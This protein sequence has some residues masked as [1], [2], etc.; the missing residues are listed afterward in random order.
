MNEMM[1]LTVG[2]FIL[3][4]ISY[5][6]SEYDFFSPSFIIC[7]MFTFGSM[8]ALYA[9]ATWG[10][11]EE[12][13]S[14][15]ATWIMLTGVMV[16]I[17]FEQITR[18]VLVGH[19]RKVVVLQ[20]KA[21]HVSTI[22]LVI[23]L[24]FSILEVVIYVY[25]VY[26]K[27]QA[28]G[29][30]GGFNFSAIA[31]FNHELTFRSDVEEGLNRGIR[32]L[33]QAAESIMFICTFV[34]CNNVILCKE[35]ILKNI[36]YLIPIIVWVPNMLI[37]S[38]RTMYLQ[39]IGA[40]VFYL[41]ILICRK[42]NW[43]RMKRNHKKIIKYAVI[44]FT[45]MVGLF[46]GAVANGLIG[47]QTNKTFMDY[48][49]V[50]IGAPIIHFHQFM[51]SPPPDVSVFGQETFTKVVPLFYRLGIIDSNYSAQMEIR[52]IIGTYSGNVYTFFRRPLHDF[53]LFGMYIIVALT[54]MG[55][56]WFYYK[57]I[58]GSNQ[59]KRND[60]NLILYSF[61]L[62]IIYIF[63]VDNALYI[64][65][66]FGIVYYIAITYFVFGLMFGSKYRFRIKKHS[67]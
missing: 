29:Y 33:H 17:L 6:L 9:T 62:Y 24:A 15:S 47:R 36:H 45:V 10:V 1:I 67:G 51:T 22:K 23:L 8:L 25:A 57:K 40:A 30:S 34:F 5:F 39:V 37:T 53:G 38:S 54:A 16:F 60:R 43:R 3:L 2:M 12:I 7:L 18:R 65:I 59:S 4:I 64:F 66:Y 44:S 61:F 58:Y 28:N 13:F 56:S 41:Y 21:Y 46:Y 52:R 26:R 27:V 50:Y 48:I 42:N 20:P 63:S 31:N 11:S 19:G 14:S 55:F 35:K 32:I 49:A